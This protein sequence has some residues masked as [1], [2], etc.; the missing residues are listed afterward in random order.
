[1]TRTIHLQKTRRAKLTNDSTADLHRLMMAWA[2]LLPPE[3]RSADFQSVYPES[4]RGTQIGNLRYS[5]EAIQ[6]FKAR[7]FLRHALI[8]LVL[9]LLFLP[10]HA[11][12]ETLRVT[13]WNLQETRGSAVTNA[14]ETAATTLK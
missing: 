8:A 10:G 3:P 12:A 1:M 5:G 11:S 2:A 9:A 6:A 13:T 14:I 4:F 7:N